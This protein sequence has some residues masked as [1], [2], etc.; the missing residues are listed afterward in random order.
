MSLPGLKDLKLEQIRDMAVAIAETR[1][2]PTFRRPRWESEAQIKQA[3]EETREFLKNSKAKEFLQKHA[4]WFNNTLYAQYARV[5]PVR[6]GMSILNGP[7]AS[8]GL[9][10]IHG[11]NNAYEGRE[12]EVRVSASLVPLSEVVV[13]L[14]SIK[15]DDTV[16]IPLEG[17]PKYQQYLKDKRVKHKDVELEEQ[18]KLAVGFT[19]VEEKIGR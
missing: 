9:R 7:V 13:S 6:E 2:I 12:V 18:I 16:L 1:K 3:G 19:P 15:K 8:V 10:W 14:S 17:S 11:R 5:E 4:D